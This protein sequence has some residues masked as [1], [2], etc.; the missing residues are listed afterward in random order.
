MDTKQYW[1][2]AFVNT[3]GLCRL[4]LKHASRTVRANYRA[5]L[6]RRVVFTRLTRNTLAA[7]LFRQVLETT[8][9]TGLARDLRRRILIMSCVARTTLLLRNICLH[10]ANRAAFACCLPLFILLIARSTIQAGQLACLRLV[11]TGCAI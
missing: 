5:D 1:A 4:K 6:C 8:G 10:F 2:C 11:P 3:R 7:A 9:F